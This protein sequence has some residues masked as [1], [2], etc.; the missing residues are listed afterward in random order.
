MGIA[1]FISTALMVLVSIVTIPLVHGNQVQIEKAVAQCENRVCTFKVTLKH[2]DSGWKHYAD[3]WRILD[4]FN[5]EI[6]R[7]TLYHPHVDEQ[8]FTRSLENVEIPDNI[9]SIWVEAHDKVHG[10]S[11]DR[12]KLTIP[13]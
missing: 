3:H 6:A 4:S 5:T 2:P 9:S 8:P 1:A 11:S 10:Y 13:E 7:R 12:F